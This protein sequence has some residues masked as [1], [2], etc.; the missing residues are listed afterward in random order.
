MFWE[1]K[2]SFSY[3][4]SNPRLSSLKPSRS[5]DY[6]DP[7]AGTKEGWKSGYTGVV[8]WDPTNRSRC[9]VSLSRDEFLATGVVSSIVKLIG[10]RVVGPTAR[11]SLLKMLCGLVKRK[12]I[13]FTEKMNLVIT[14]WLPLVCC[15]RKWGRRL[16]SRNM[17]WEMWEQNAYF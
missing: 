16:A 12:K 17:W 6:T 1:K 3:P 8:M 14:A 13:P 5:T 11:Y 2:F 15:S 4:D 7:P 9:R 10:R